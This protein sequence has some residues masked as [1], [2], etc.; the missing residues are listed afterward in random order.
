MGDKLDIRGSVGIPRPLYGYASP[1]PGA[2]AEKSMDTASD[3]R[4][5]AHRNQREGRGKEIRDEKREREGD[6][7]ENKKVQGIDFR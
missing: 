3:K 6:E 1:G 4:P 2:L 7:K 5:R